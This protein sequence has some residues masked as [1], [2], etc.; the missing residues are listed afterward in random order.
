MSSW[1]LGPYRAVGHCF[2]VRGNDADQVR[3]RLEHALAPLADLT[4]GPSGTYQVTDHGPDAKTR[5][6]LHFDGTCI[7]A[8]DCP[9]HLAG[10]VVW[11]VNG[12]VVRV[13]RGQHL[14]LHA[15]AAERDG[16]TVVLPAPMES[17]KTTTVAGLLRAGYRYVTDETVVLD[18]ADLAITAFPKALALDASA[19]R[20][21]GGVRLPSYRHADSDTQQHVTW[22]ELGSPGVATGGSPGLVVFPEFR[23]GATT[24]LEPLTPAAAVLEMAASTFRFRERPRRNLDVL[25]RLATAVPAYRLAIGDLDEAVQAIDGLVREHADRMLTA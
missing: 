22:W 17:G 19:V 25:A 8:S 21:L 10:L 3:L 6:T 7:V 16:V 13:D 11:H 1:V 9:F 23:H 4:A 20:L 2:V 15:S 5:Y 18:R 12:S 24:A 14:L